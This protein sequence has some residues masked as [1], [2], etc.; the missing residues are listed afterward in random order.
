M[1][2]GGISQQPAWQ[3][4]RSKHSQSPLPSAAAGASAS[5]PPLFLALPEIDI[6]GSNDCRV[7]FPALCAASDCL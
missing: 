1:H 7:T 2:P 3:A 4:A 5:L 6:Q